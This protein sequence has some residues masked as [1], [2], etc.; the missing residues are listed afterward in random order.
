M[1]THV[2]IFLFFSFPFLWCRWSNLLT[3][4]D[5]EFLYCGAVAAAAT[6]LT[7]LI[8]FYSSFAC[9]SGNRMFSSVNWGW[10]SQ[11]TWSQKSQEER[12]RWIFLGGLKKKGSVSIE[13]FNIPSLPHWHYNKDTH[14][15]SNALRGM[16][17]TCCS[18][19][20]S[21]LPSFP[22]I[23]LPRLFLCRIPFPECLHPCQNWDCK[24]NS[25]AWIMHG[26]RGDANLSEASWAAKT[27]K[28]IPKIL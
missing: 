10:T 22:T 2:G 18:E 7:L 17:P 3:H 19:V 28:R 20:A 4:P 26:K 8:L 12:E 5:W 24:V 13:S 6:E 15:K 21:L 14:L 27:A 1:H 23:K 25:Y 16:Q 9:C 11:P